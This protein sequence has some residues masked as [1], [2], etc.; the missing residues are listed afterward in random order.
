MTLKASSG[1]NYIGCSASSFATAGLAC[2][3]KQHLILLALCRTKIAVS[4]SEL[5]T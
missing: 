3:N 2:K 1:T 4:G 5:F